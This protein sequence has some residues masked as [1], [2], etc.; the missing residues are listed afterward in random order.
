MNIKTLAKKILGRQP[1]YGFF[2]FFDTWQEA[3]KQS[4]GWNSPHILDKV[5]QNLLKVKRGEAAYERDSVLF[6]QIQYSWPLLCGLL[7]V[8]LE[9]GGILH[10]ADFGGSLGT[11][12]FQ[13][14]E[15]LSGLEKLEWNIIEQENY[16]AC[17]KK[18][19]E[20]EELRFFPSIEQCL[21]KTKPDVLIVSSVIQYLEDPFAM[22]E[23]FIN[24]KFKY[25]IFDRTSFID[26]PEHKIAIQKVKPAI[27]DAVFPIWFFNY[28]KFLTL[29]TGQYRVAAEFDA[30]VAS[31][32]EVS[33]I[34][35]GDKGF[36]LK[37]L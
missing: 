6:D 4:R 11:T 16:V 28:D 14:R 31:H 23:K 24:A 15:F 18:Y 27:Y 22:I 5:C 3:L 25:V 1:R 19:F 20:N 12:Y 9:N 33:G 37:R 2:G 7:R 10:V 36:I 32:Y 29:F 35:G 30:F 21:K 26:S 17:G 34:P 13:N 8:A